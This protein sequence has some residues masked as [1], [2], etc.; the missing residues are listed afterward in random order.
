[1]ISKISIGIALLLIHI[2]AF[3]QSANIKQNSKSEKRDSVK[4]YNVQPILSFGN[5]K[6]NNVSVEDFKNGLTFNVSEK[7][8]L[9]SMTIYFAG[10][11]F[12]NT[13][14]AYVSGNGI[15]ALKSLMDKLTK[16]SIVAFDN[17]KLKGKD[18]IRNFQG[19]K[20]TLY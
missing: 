2:T 15:G 19:R 8:S 10:V 20:F 1:M 3:A 4:T 12:P 16:G 5:F 7:Y 18:G 14:T 17:I 11:G 13:I 6:S 9:I